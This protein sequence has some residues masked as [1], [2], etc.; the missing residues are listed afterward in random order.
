MSRKDII[1]PHFGHPGPLDRSANI[2]YPIRRCST[3]L[4]CRGPRT[5]GTTLR[6]SCVRKVTDICA[7]ITKEFFENVIFAMYATRRNSIAC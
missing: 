1:A 6:K 2:A 5:N 3:F 4:A 7:A